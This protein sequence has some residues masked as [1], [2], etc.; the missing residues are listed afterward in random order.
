MFVNTAKCGEINTIQETV[1]FVPG[2]WPLGGWSSLQASPSSRRRGS[3]SWQM[4]SL[5]WTVVGW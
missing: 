5:A 4:F 1:C 3:A 2:F